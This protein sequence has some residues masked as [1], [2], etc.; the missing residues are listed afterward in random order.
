MNQE[1]LEKSKNNLLKQLEEKKK[2]K[3]FKKKT[4][5]ESDFSDQFGSNEK[6]F[7]PRGRG[8]GM[9]PKNTKTI[10]DADGNQIFIM[11]DEKKNFSK[12]GRAMLRGGGIC[13]KG[14]N[15]KAIGRNS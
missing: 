12:G 13:K 9:I 4:K 3:K 6:K 8:G 10:E 5:E 1:K 14:M 11:T 7:G 2:I 15:K